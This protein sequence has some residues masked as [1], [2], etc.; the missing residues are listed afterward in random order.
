MYYAD[1]MRGV[2]F[3]EVRCKAALNRVQGMP[4]R[5]SANPYVGCTHACQY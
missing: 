4:F 2:E 5:W 3:V 1:L